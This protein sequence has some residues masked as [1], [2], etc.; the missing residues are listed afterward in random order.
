MKGKL[1]GFNH[2]QGVK[3]DGSNYEFVNAFFE[4]P[5]PETG[6]G[7]NVDSF[8]SYDPKL[9]QQVSSVSK[10]PVKCY[11]S[12]SNNYLSDIDLLET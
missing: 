4:I 5:T 1:I 7:I 3:K 12:T 10:F 8:R 11:F 6:K 9:I 2:V